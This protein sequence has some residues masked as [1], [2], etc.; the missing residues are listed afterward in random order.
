MNPTELKRRALRGPRSRDKRPLELP[1]RVVRLSNG[2]YTVQISGV[3]SGMS[4][5]GGLA[6]TRWVP[7]PTSDADGF[8]LYLRDLEQ[9]K[10]WSA[11]FQPTLVLPDEYDFVVAPGAVEIGRIDDEIESRMTVCVDPSDDLELRVCRLTN[12]GDR[13]RKIEL[14]SYVEFVLARRDAD[15]SHPTFLKLFIETEFCWERNAILARR[16]PR[17]ATESEQWACHCLLGDDADG[18]SGEIQFETNRS[19]FIGRG[20]SMASPRALDPNVRLTSDWGAVL[21][22]IGSLRTVVSLG[23]GETRQIVWTLGAANSRSEIE[24]LATKVTNLAEVEAVFAAATQAGELQSQENHAAASIRLDG[25]PAN[26]LIIHPPHTPSEPSVVDPQREPLYRAAS[27]GSNGGAFR[28][29]KPD[30]LRFDNGYGGF[31]ADGRE[32]VIRVKTD[33]ERGQILPPRPWANV[34]ANPS[35]GFLVTERGAGY[36]WA[37]NSR[38]NRLTAWHND[39]VCDPHAEAIWIRDEAAKSFWSVAPGPTPA[40]V[41]FEVRHGFG[42]STFCHVSHGLEQELTLFMEREEPVKFARVRLTNRGRVARRLSLFSYA[43]WNLGSLITDSPGS[44]STEYD[45]NSRAILARNPN[46]ELF[47][48][49]VAFSAVAIEPNKDSAEF[50]FTGDR[51]TFLGELGRLESPAAL[52]SGQRLDNRTGGRLD[53]CA[54][55]QVPIELAAGETVECTILLGETATADAAAELIRK[56]RGAGEVGRALEQAKAFWNETLTAVQVQT[57]DA[58]IDLLVNGWLSYQNLSC[59][60]WGRSAYYQPGGAFGFRDQLQDSAALLFHRPDLTRQQIIRHAGQQFAEGDVLHFWHPDTGAGLRTRFSDDL[61][62]LPYIAATYIAVTGDEQVL[63]EVAPFVSGS[64]LT[65][66]QQEAYLHVEQT[67]QSATIYEHCCRAIDRGLTKGEHGLPLFGCGDWNDG[68]NRVGAQGRGES[69]WLGFFIASVLELMIPI[70]RRRGDCERADRYQAYRE[71]L[72]TALNTAGWDGSWYRRAYYDDGEPLGSAQSDECQIDALAQSWAVLSGVAPK[73]RAAMCISAVEERLV[74]EQAGIIRLLAPAFN[75]TMH[76]PGY[77]KGYLPGIRENGGQYTHGVLW[78]IRALAELGRGTRAVELLKMLSPV[79]HTLTPDAVA[80]YQTEPYVVAADVYGEPPHVGR[81]GWTWYTGSAGWM[82]RVA[83]ESVFGFSIEQ[84]QRLVIN[85]AISASWPRCRL[86]YRVPGSETRYEIK[87]ENPNAR[88]R[89]VVS[90]TVDG[91][92]ADVVDGAAVVP[93][94]RDGRR[95]EVVVRL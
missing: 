86:S 4:E 88:E 34:I 7:D 41:T 26:H 9:G 65:A 3:G 49:A 53:P 70:C 28:N 61:L 14:T 85:P 71:Q 84:G 18:L 63:D 73:E 81:G 16:R 66:E 50:T 15:D 76:D 20:R 45:T 22:P 19:R 75:R 29:G 42:Y 55:W 12:H 82:L 77:I 67:E 91:Q 62:W 79:S 35:A 74:D 21:D 33:H 90:A 17:S 69:V 51:T 72:L 27:N 6:V 54:A 44:V 46:R 95:H 25:S 47:R 58:E 64:E 13:P 48:D 94:A 24:R 92:S 30:I 1:R 57:P 93:L 40:A 32:Y 59:R 31:S 10:V 83:V 5:R 78:Y 23:A 89:G 68:M 80:I 2:S 60:M 52:A 36:S 11:G 38:L 87:I 37:G 39:A 8:H 43:H 56:Y